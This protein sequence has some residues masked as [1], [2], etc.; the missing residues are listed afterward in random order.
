MDWAQWFPHRLLG[1]KGSQ[2]LPTVEEYL[3]P[4]ARPWRDSGTESEMLEYAERLANR[5]AEQRESWKAIG[6]RK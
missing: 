6:Q 2:Q 3:K 1:Y 4:P 5:L